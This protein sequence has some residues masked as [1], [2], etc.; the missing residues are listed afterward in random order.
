MINHHAGGVHMAANAAK[1]AELASTRRWAADMDD[2]Q[3][4]EIS[5]MNQLAH[6]ARAPD[7][8]AAARRVHP[9]GERG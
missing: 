3:R 4:G 9:A 5:E 7:D 1:H 8:R 6:P 2:G